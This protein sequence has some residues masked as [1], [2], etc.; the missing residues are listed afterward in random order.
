MLKG[1]KQAQDMLKTGSR[2]CGEFVAHLDLRV[3]P[4]QIIGSGIG[5]VWLK[6]IRMCGELVAHVESSSLVE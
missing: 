4:K 6:R 2:M 5:Y 1:S 3:D